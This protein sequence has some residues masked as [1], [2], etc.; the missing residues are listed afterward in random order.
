MQRRGDWD[1][2]GPYRLVESGFFH[3]SDAKIVGKSIRDRVSLIKW[4]RERTVP[5]R[6][7]EEPRVVEKPGGPDGVTLPGC[8][9]APSEPE[10]PEAD[11]HVRQC[12]LPASATSVT[13]PCFAPYFHLT[14]GM[15]H[16]QWQRA[17]SERSHLRQSRYELCIMRPLCNGPESES[18]WAT[19]HKADGTFDSGLGSTVYSDSHSSKHSV[20]YQSLLDT[21]PAATQQEPVCFGGCCHCS[22]AWHC[23]AVLEG[24]LNTRRGSASLI[25]ALKSSTRLPQNLRPPKSPPCCCRA[26]SPGCRSVSPVPRPPAK[27]DEPPM[28]ETGDGDYCSTLK[29]LLLLHT[30]VPLWESRRHSDSSMEPSVAQNST[31]PVASWGIAGEHLERRHSDFGHMLSPTPGPP[32][33]RACISLHR[34]QRLCGCT[35][36]MPTLANRGALESAE[37]SLLHKSLQHIIGPK[38]RSGSL[39]AYSGTERATHRLTCSHGEA[40]TR[41]HPQLQDESRGRHRHSEEAVPPL[42]VVCDMS[43]HAAEVD[44]SVM[45]RQR[46]G[47]QHARL[48]SCPVI[49]ADTALIE[50]RHSP[51]LLFCA[52]EQTL[53]S[54]P[55]LLSAL[56]G[57][58]G[59][60][61]PGFIRT[62]SAGSSVLPADWAGIPNCNEHQRAKPAKC[63]ILQF[64]H[65]N[66]PQQPQYQLCNI[67]N[68]LPSRF[69]L[70]R[71][72]CSTLR[73]HLSHFA[74]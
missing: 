48:P 10:E 39:P 41:P 8:P 57:Q 16:G 45:V 59:S 13:W 23:A 28:D 26:P 50:R 46:K 63:T 73:F 60:S 36:G 2:S 71:P 7:G 49:L 54:S 74:S 52:P 72:L 34:P 30:P 35:D 62:T 44:P 66:T 55:A 21:I 6:D 29:P 14:L 1:L 9:A 15:S 43:G 17:T 31:A 3:E 25:E 68:I 70:L 32:C 56:K 27:A 20:P 4:K 18:L 64:C 12:D 67:A 53:L 69:Q 37:L 40:A 24:C 65:V 11:Q 51:A 33:C 19:G 47:A 42:T 5:I 38:S 22:G 61:N 58:A